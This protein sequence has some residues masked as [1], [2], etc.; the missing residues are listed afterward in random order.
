M[1]KRAR[2]V[3]RLFL[4]GGGAG[5]DG[6]NGAWWKSGCDSVEEYRTCAVCRMDIDGKRGERVAGHSPERETH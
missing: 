3:K 2:R 6:G 4:G 1:L 5:C